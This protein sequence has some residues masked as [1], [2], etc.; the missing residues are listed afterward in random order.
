MGLGAHSGGEGSIAAHRASFASGT[1]VSTGK[2]SQAVFGAYNIVDTEAQLVVGAGTADARANVFACGKT[3]D[4]DEKWIT[5]GNT[6]ITEA[7][8]QRLL[9]LI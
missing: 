4:T 8:L 5:I 2:E 6:K 9:S 3:A 7:Q 1:Y